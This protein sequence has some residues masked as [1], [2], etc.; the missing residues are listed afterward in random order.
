MRDIEKDMNM[1]KKKKMNFKERIILKKK[2]E[3]RF[4]KIR[5][6]EGQRGK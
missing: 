4:Y 1:K 5:K 6:R 3:G 2:W